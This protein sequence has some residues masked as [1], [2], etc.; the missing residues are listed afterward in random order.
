LLEL[1][2]SSPPLIDLVERIGRDLDGRTL[3]ALSRI[4]ANSGFIFRGAFSSCTEIECTLFVQVAFFG[5]GF[6]CTEKV[7][8]R[9][10]DILTP[11]Q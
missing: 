3:L 8:R 2:I 7:H 1:P 5:N 11:H 4:L 9:E 6:T 10:S